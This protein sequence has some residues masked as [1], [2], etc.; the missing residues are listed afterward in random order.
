MF[1][2]ANALPFNGGS[3]FIQRIS[4]QFLI[5]H[6]RI[7]ILI[8]TN[9][10][11]HELETKL[12]KVADIYYL[13]DYQTIPLSKICNTQIGIFMS[14]DI[15][16]IKNIIKKYGRHVHTMGLFGLLFIA[17]IAHATKNPFDISIGIYQQYE[18]MFVSK[19]FLAQYSQKI[20]KELGPKHI[21]FFNEDNIKSYSR[22]FSIDYT[23]SLLVPIGIQLPSA[24]GSFGSHKTLKIISIGNLY[25]FKMYNLHIVNLM[26]QLLSINPNFTYE[27]YGEG[28]LKKDLST[29]I[30]ELNLGKNVFLKGNI[31]YQEFSTVVKDAFLFVGSGTAILEASALGIPSII[32]IESTESA[33]TYGFLSDISGFSYNEYDRTRQTV[34]ILQLIK[35]IAIDSQAWDKTSKECIEKAKEFSIEKTFD[36][37]VDLDSRNI[38]VDLNIFSTYNNIKLFVSF[39]TLGLKQY[40]HIDNSF[41]KR[42]D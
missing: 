28:E 40:M 29:L 15:F 23:K 21:V 13:Q 37:F 7:G 1:I 30:T 12:A 34:P 6:K 26:P 4:E 38:P 39:F 3:T 8:L 31:P 24:L 32:G 35:K 9:V 41:S 33:I 17:R 14:I 16:K 25:K 2:I 18:M 27:I 36:G 20:L 42:R 19:S 11:D 10:I 22:F 5:N